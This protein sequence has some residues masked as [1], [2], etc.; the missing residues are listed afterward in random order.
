MIERASSHALAC[1]G[2]EWAEWGE[3]W[4]NTTAGRRDKR[5]SPVDP[6]AIAWLGFGRAG[7]SGRVPRLAFSAMKS[8]MF[9]ALSA[10]HAFGG[11][12][13]TRGRQRSADLG[14]GASAAPARR[15]RRASSTRCCGRRRK[16]VTPRVMRRLVSVPQATGARPSGADGISFSRNRLFSPARRVV[17]KAR[18]VRHT[19]RAFRSAPLTAHL[20]YL[21]RDGVTRKRREGGDVRRRQRPH[22]RRGLRGSLQG[23]PAS[24]PLHRLARGRRRA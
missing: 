24:F 11:P 3:R 16:P 7:R 22:R 20:S 6:Q 1:S 13:M 4:E 9:S 5:G 12:A 15:S 10:L 18:V 14:P 2:E 23:R 8:R 21:K 19:G 17:V